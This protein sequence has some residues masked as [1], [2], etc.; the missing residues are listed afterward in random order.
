MRKKLGDRRPPSLG[1]GVVWY[2]LDYNFS[3]LSVHYVPFLFLLFLINTVYSVVH[4]LPRLSFPKAARPLTDPQVKT[5]PQ[6]PSP[7]S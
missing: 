2:Y 7:P 5:P 6:P 4:F 3:F 1:Q